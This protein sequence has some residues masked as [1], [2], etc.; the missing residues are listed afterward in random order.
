MSKE[1][2]NNWFDWL[3]F[4]WDI[5]EDILEAIMDSFD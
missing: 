2:K 4:I 3:E 1:N 5:I